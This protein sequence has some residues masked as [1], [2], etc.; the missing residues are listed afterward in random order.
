[1]YK[2]ELRKPGT[3]S[4]IVAIKEAKHERLNSLFVEEADVMA[5]L[6]H[7]NILK[8]L[9]IIKDEGVSKILLEFMEKGDLVDAIMRVKIF[10]Y[11]YFKHNTHCR[12]FG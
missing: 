10:F 9:A 6:D 5:Q 1:M 11:I 12:R 3:P 2:G 7:E 8:V 4:V